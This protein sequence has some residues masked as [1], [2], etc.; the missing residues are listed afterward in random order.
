MA[1]VVE[2][3]DFDPQRFINDI[4]ITVPLN[5]IRINCPKG[6]GDLRRIQC[7]FKSI[8][9]KVNP[10]RFKTKVSKPHFAL[11]ELE[12]ETISRL[13]N[14]NVDVYLNFLFSKKATKIKLTKSSPSI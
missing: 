13:N 1:S 14:K 11:V 2:F 3:T 9:F 8:T 6:S 4:L 10:K 7:N 12:T 5:E